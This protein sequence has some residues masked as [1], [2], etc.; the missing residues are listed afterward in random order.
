VPKR[1]LLFTGHR[2]DDDGRAKPRFPKDKEQIAREA[3]SR[4]VQDERASAGEIA[5]GIAGGASGGDILFHEVCRDLGVQTHLY[6]ALPAEKFITYSVA[7]AGPGWVDRFNVLRDERLQQ[8][9]TARVRVLQEVE[10]LPRWLNGK[11]NY[12]VWPRD[13]LWMLYNALAYG[14]TKVTVI[15]LWDKGEGD[16][17]GGTADLVS[18]AKARGAKTVILNTK[19]LFGLP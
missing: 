15:A 5:Y 11:S 16:G 14:A 10:A 6:L 1:V 9:E 12:G 19:E 4:A 18:Q 13:N 8:N 7:S 3:I 17:P 2:V